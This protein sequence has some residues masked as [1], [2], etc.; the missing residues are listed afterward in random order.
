[1]SDLVKEIK[2]KARRE[3]GPDYKKFLPEY[4][5]VQEIP[6]PQEIERNTKYLTSEELAKKVEII[7]TIRL[8]RGERTTITSTPV[9]NV[10]INIGGGSLF[11]IIGI[12]EELENSRYSI[13]RDVIEVIGG[14]NIETEKDLYELIQSLPHEDW[15]SYFYRN[16]D[17]LYTI[18]EIKARSDIREL[19]EGIGFAL[20][21]FYFNTTFNFVGGKSPSERVEMRANR[22]L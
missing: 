1:M 9:K 14:I 16:L 4:K 7:D 6:S 15:H 11:S 20:T 21:E 17:K 12:L 18:D 3:I 5:V 19:N 8:L 10:T 13:E 22:Y 2:E